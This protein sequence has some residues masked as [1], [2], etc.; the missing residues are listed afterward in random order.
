MFKSRQVDHGPSLVTTVVDCMHAWWSKDRVRASP[1]EGRLL[2]VSLGS[3]LVIRCIRYEVVRRN[4]LGT[5]QD[6]AVRYLCE[7]PDGPAE[8]RVTASDVPA[9]LL[10]DHG[11]EYELSEAELEIWDKK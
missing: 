5:P 2:R 7:G 6:A 10:I 8:L 4:L 1:R 11:S 3:I 9:I